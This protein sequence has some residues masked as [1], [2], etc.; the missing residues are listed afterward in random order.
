MDVGDGK[1]ASEKF[2][3]SGVFAGPQFHVVVVRQLL[4]CNAPGI[5]MVMRKQQDDHRR[6][7][8]NLRRAAEKGSHRTAAKYEHKN[9][10]L[11]R[12]HRYSTVV[13]PCR[14]FFLC[15]NVLLEA[16]PLRQINR[17]LRFNELLEVVLVLRDIVIASFSERR[18]RSP[19][20]RLVS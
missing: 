1:S 16:V 10:R 14:L 8:R 11:L 18:C 19:D 3:P 4:V 15:I 9:L 17:I 20:N 6:L 2:L 12:K 13:L 5:R 7:G